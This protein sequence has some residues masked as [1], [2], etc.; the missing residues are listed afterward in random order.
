MRSGMNWVMTAASRQH[1]LD[2]IVDPRL[3]ERRPGQR[4]QCGAADADHDPGGDDYLADILALDA[5]ELI[6]LSRQVRRGGEELL[7]DERV[8]TRR[9]EKRQLGRLGG[10]GNLDR[11]DRVAGL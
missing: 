10:A 4:R 6:G 2:E 7:A 5:S 9:H 11:A 3:N 1:P 8:V